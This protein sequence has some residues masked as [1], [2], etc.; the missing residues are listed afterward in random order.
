LIWPTLG[1][2]WFPN[3]LMDK[4]AKIGLA[5]LNCGEHTEQSVAGLKVHD[6][7]FCFA[8]GSAINLTTPENRTFI[9][10]LSKIGASLPILGKRQRERAA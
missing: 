9:D 4:Y 8:Y 5:C 3:K 2:G 1:V 6:R 7:L 10:Q